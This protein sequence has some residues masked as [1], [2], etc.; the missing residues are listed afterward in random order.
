MT[1]EGITKLLG[2]DFEVTELDKTGNVARHWSHTR[3][4]KVIPKERGRPS[5][6]SRSIRKVLMDSFLPIGYPHSV[7]EDYLAYQFFDSLQAF[8]STIT[9]LLANRAL[10]QG[11]GVG[12]AN[13]SATFA[14]L[15]TVLKDAI[16]RIATIIFAQQFGLRIEPDAKRYRFL[17]DLFNDTAFFL[18][19]YSPYLGSFGK[20]IALTT[21]EA[22]R[23]LCG[24]AAGASKAS[25]SQHF[26]RHDNLAEL[27]AKEASQ[28][29]AVGL[30]GL[31]AG[32][33]F[34][35]Y[36][37]DPRS[38]VYLMIVLVFSHLLMNYWGVRSVCVDTL[39]RQRATILFE[40]YLK[41]G[42]ILS[43]TEVA[44]RENILFWRPVVRNR[45]GKPTARI[46]MAESYQDA[47][48]ANRRNTEITVIDCSSHKYTLFLWSHIRYT[49]T[50]IK[51]MLWND[52]TAKD[53][54]AAWFM[55][56]EIAWLMEGEDYTKELNRTLNGKG[57]RSWTAKG[58][59]GHE[60]P[61]EDFGDKGDS[62]SQ[63]WED[64]SVQGQWNLQSQ[65]LETAAPVRLLAGLEDKKDI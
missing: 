34:V 53:A 57:L 4:N 37:E 59:L 60:Q 30:V 44:Y 3:D 21:G 14:M 47:M 15:L 25:L 42:K 64:I 8:F 26:A 61:D 55:S 62:Y 27:N 24:V 5:R 45:Q 36:I 33:F 39:N 10:L 12:D 22:L 28:E 13:S 16:S 40:E 56:M 23:A 65:S 6:Y 52:A 46:D 2:R 50:P 32:T 19:L 63:F 29:T 43:P 41:T 49:H 35:K 51:I 18:E 54:L 17:A 1:M 48:R 9:A 20:I 11:L 38:V 31:L 7:S 58:S